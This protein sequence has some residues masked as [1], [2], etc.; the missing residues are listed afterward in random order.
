MKI[1]YVGHAALLIEVR[2]LRILS[3]PWWQGPCFGYQWWIY[4]AP[5]LEPVNRVPID[6]IYISH[7][8]ADHFHRGT[9]RRFPRG[10][11]V[12]V[13]GGFDIATELREMG[14]SV[15][16]VP[17]DEAWRLA[18]GVTCR[19]L[20]T[21]GQDSLMALSDGTEVCIN[22]N[23]ALHSA[24]SD[25][26]E[27]VT[28]RL[29]EY[30]PRIDYVYCGF[31]TA[32]HFPNCYVIPGKNRR[33]TAI[34]R[35]RHF[36]LQWARVISLLQPTY[37]F[38]FAADV[39]LLEPE[40][41]WCNE[42][43]RNERPIAAITATSPNLETIAIDVA[44]GFTI[45]DGAIERDV[46]AHP[47]KAEEVRAQ[48][49]DEIERISERRR[50]GHNDVEV[51]EQKLRQ[52]VEICSSYLQEYDKDYRFLILFFDAQVGLE[53]IR[54]GTVI[55]VSTVKTDGID[56]NCYDLTFTTYFSYLRR[57]LMTAYGNETMFVG[58][59]CVIEYRDPEAASSNLHCELT[60]LLCDA[61][62]PDHSRFGRQP[63]WLFRLKRSIK[64]LIRYKAE[65]D[66]YDLSRWTLFGAPRG[67]FEWLDE[68]VRILEAE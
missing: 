55:T 29:R 2:G 62:K 49:A 58:S 50:R 6:Y 22:V 61:P 7:G 34:N 15:I 20:P 11:K 27:Q 21:H 45:A 31:G 28:A 43:V 57:A 65:P 9:L 17:T 3:D 51:L 14:F 44:P 47:V 48:F 42:A 16:E 66:L 18:D 19:I 36:N 38:P 54:Q 63:R 23:D 37:G 10:T 56:R 40:L 26:Q 64:S 1:T 68:E 5:F 41:F 46:R 53:L 67:R 35:Q 8:H 24:P 12:L 13:A 25:I 30:Y 32:S 4:P 60:E 39:V 33:D 52:N 59:G